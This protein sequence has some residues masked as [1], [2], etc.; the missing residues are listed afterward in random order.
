VKN[1]IYI[2]KDGLFITISL[3]LIVIF[4]VN[5]ESG[6]NDLDLFLLVPAI[7]FGIA[8]I[9]GLISKNK[10][11]KTNRILNTYLTFFAILF[12]IIGIIAFAVLLYLMNRGFYSN[13]G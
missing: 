6:L 3:V 13:G 4:Y 12:L 8:G 5:Q 9:H 1:K 10:N 11:T 7:P 2:L